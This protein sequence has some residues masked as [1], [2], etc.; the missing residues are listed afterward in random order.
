MAAI[1][2]DK[3]LGLFLTFWYLPYTDYPGSE[4]L[5]G[6]A[7]IHILITVVRVGL[8]F[9]NNGYGAGC[10]T[11]GRSLLYDFNIVQ[12]Q[13]SLVRYQSISILTIFAFVAKLKALNFTPNKR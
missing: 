8:Y 2:F 9:E 11:S 4:G 12:Y 5:R 6:N 10:S 7:F 3:M 13:K 1:A